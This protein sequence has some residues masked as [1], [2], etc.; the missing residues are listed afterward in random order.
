MANTYITRT[1]GSAATNHDKA[2]ISFWLKRCR[3]GVEESVFGAYVD[4]NNRFKFRFRSDDKFDFEL[5]VGSSWYSLISNQKFRDRTGWM[6]FVIAY[7][8]SQGTASDRTKIYVN[9]TQVTDLGT[10]NYVPQNQDFYFTKN[11]V[12]IT[13]G[14]NYQ[15]GSH[16]NYF[17][18][19]ISHFHCVDGLALTPNYFGQTDTTS[20]EWKLGGNQGAIT[21][22]NNGFFI[23]KDS[24][25][26]TDQSGN[27]NNWSSGGGNLNNTI[28]NPSDNFCTWNGNSKI[29]NGSTSYGL[30]RITGSQ[31]DAYS[32]NAVGSIAA[33]KGKYYCEV[34]YTSA[35]A[36]N[37]NPCLG[38][39]NMDAPYQYNVNITTSTN[40]YIN[41]RFT[42]DLKVNNVETTGWDT[43]ITSAGTIIM[44]AMDL[45]NWKWYIGTNGTWYNSANPS[46]GTNGVSI[47]PQS[48]YWSWN[49]RHLGATFD[50]N[51]GNGFF[52]T[53]A[54]SSA[55]T[56]ASNI[57]SFEYDVPTGFTALS[58]KGINSF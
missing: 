8:S 33:A 7:D 18:G 20:G 40:G 42:G 38:I 32:S 47:S 16:Q 6:H 26:L 48:G 5:G 3:G 51:F 57:G 10:A 55:G 49:C 53:T 44:M 45:D 15:G 28:D 21:Y 54:I 12:G 34:K 14:D 25:S 56:N 11:G 29:D 4:D 35:N 41:F 43:A 19:L 13:I 17:D 37:N 22:G 23:L 39:V 2:T 1:N 24:A 31:D 52:G 58:T 27:T 36:T 30:T 9:G 50:A 46:S